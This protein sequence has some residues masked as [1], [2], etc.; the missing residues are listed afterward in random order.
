MKILTIVV[1]GLLVVIG[2]MCMGMMGVSTWPLIA[3]CVVI[4]TIRCLLMK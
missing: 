1:Y 3:V 4:G 2:A